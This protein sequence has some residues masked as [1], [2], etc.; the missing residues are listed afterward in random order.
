MVQQP[1]RQT[2][3][4]GRTRD[5]ELP[6]FGRWRFRAQPTARS[7]TLCLARARTLTTPLPCRRQVGQT[8]VVDKRPQQE[9]YSRAAPLVSLLPGRE[10]VRLRSEEVQVLLESTSTPN[11]GQMA[12]D[13]M[14]VYCRRL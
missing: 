13:I 11:I 14:Q 7:A 8:P 4:S 6:R 3:P 12:D 5:K 9:Q 1:N 10:R 2:A